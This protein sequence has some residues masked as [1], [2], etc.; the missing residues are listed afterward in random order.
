MP[1]PNYDI[2]GKRR[3]EGKL[4][5]KRQAESY[6]DALKLRVRVETGELAR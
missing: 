3:D 4:A 1:V 5:E 2:M 6:R